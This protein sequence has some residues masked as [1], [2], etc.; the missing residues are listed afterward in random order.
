VVEIVQG[1]LE[2]TLLVAGHLEGVCADF[3]CGDADWCRELDGFLKENAL[4]E[5]AQR[6]NSTYIFTDESGAAV[7]YV[8]VAT[9]V[10]PRKKYS[11]LPM[12]LVT[13]TYRFC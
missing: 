7:A 12:R 2:Y 9:A 6:L 13:P 1:T 11:W 5:G 4:P 8:A 10:L 3:S